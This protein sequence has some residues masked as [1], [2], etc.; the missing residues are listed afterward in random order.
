MA[1]SDNAAKFLKKRLTASI[2]L[3]QKRWGNVSLKV[4]F[5]ED[6]N[7]FTQF[8][9]SGFV[10]ILDELVTR[11]KLGKIKTKQLTLH[12]VHDNKSRSLGQN[13]AVAVLDRKTGMQRHLEA[14]HRSGF[15]DAC[16]SSEAFE[17]ELR[18]DLPKHEIDQFIT[19]IEF[20]VK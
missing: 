15:L 6:S 9:R 17:F 1:L 19:S 10:T 13:Y 18:E 3:T 5:A 14:L 16:M 11:K 2:T 7:I 4:N 20:I 8:A 12:W